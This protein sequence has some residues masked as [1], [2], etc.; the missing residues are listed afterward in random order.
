M[1]LGLNR[2]YLKDTYTIGKLYVDSRYFCETLE[3]KVRDLS[4]YNHD[5]D[6]DDLEEG[7]V[8]GQTAIPAGRY[9]VIMHYWLKHKKDVP[10]LLDVP[11]F[12]GILIHGGSTAEHTL[13]CILV[14]QNKERGKLT[15]SSYYIYLLIDAIKNA[16]NDKEEV[17]ITVKQ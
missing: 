11:G 13:G 3:D 17:F 4:D 6:F 14:G 8:Y 10:M 12:S 7:K 15:N 9:K 5:G 2:K 16:I 1:E